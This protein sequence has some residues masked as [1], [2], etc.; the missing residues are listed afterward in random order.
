MIGAFFILD[1]PIFNGLGANN[2][3]DDA[4]TGSS[5]STLA[6]VAHQAPGHSLAGTRA[7]CPRAPSKSP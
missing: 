3:V 6:A 5:G 7:A 4:A 2:Q 1:E